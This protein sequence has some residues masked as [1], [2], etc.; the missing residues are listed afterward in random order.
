MVMAK[1]PGVLPNSLLLPLPPFCYVSGVSECF[2]ESWSG[3]E[4]RSSVWLS[5]ILLATWNWPYFSVCKAQ[6]LSEGLAP[7]VWLRWQCKAVS[8]SGKSLGCS[9]HFL[10]VPPQWRIPPELG[11]DPSWSAFFFLSPM[12][13]DAGIQAWLPWSSGHQHRSDN[14]ENLGIAFFSPSAILFQMFILKILSYVMN[15]CIHFVIHIQVLQKSRKPPWLPFLIP[16][17]YYQLI[18]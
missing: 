3:P 7:F 11:W 17:P 12:Q 8:L 4:G 2:I 10:L 13:K 15:I 14:C 1:G 16:S 9:S 6:K 5:P 18:L